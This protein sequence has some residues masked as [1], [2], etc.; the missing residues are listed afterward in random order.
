LRTETTGLYLGESEN[1]D[2]QAR[3]ARMDDRQ[4]VWDTDRNQFQGNTL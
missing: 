4:S 1:E 3:G 2:C